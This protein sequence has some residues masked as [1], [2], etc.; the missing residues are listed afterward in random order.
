MISSRSTTQIVAIISLVACPL[1][2]APGQTANDQGSKTPAEIAKAIA[3]TIDISTVK[4]PGAPITFESATSHDNVVELR[5]VANDAAALSRL[6]SKADQMRL[7]KTSYY[8]NESRI[9]YL[10]QGIVM[11]EILTTAGNTEQIEFTFDIS[12]CGSLPKSKLADSETLAEFALS[13]AKTENEGVGKSSNSPFRFDGATARQGVV[14]LRFIVLDASAMA[15][16]ARSGQ[17]RGV[18]TGY[19]CSKYRD[20]ISQGLA[21]HHVFVLQDG[22][23]MTDFTTDRS[24]C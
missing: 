7:V 1:G 24:S 22:S 3:H 6:K 21:L 17:L 10:K 14:D 23:P 15:A 20:F 16:P 18:L 8:C 19:F 11:H 9:A 4:T 13:V 5:F 2:E 12:S